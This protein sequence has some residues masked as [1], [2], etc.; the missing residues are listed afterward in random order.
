[1][2][3]IP[4]LI[5]SKVPDFNTASFNTNPIGTGPFLFHKRI[6]GSHTEYKKNPN[7]HGSVSQ[8]ESFIHKYVPDQTVLY[9]QLKTGEI[10]F[11]YYLVMSTR[12]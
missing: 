9:T 3:I 5:L 2:H 10:D 11:L 4:E 8:L 6:P 7:Y 1:M 12:K